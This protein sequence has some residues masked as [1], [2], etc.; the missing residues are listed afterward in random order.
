MINLK[1][2]EKEYSEI[3]KEINIFVDDI[4]KGKDIEGYYFN[5]LRQEVEKLTRQINLGLLSPN[6][7]EKIY[8]VFESI[9]ILKEQPNSKN[10]KLNEIINDLFDFLKYVIEYFMFEVENNFLVKEDY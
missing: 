8:E 4:N 3:I 2:Q 1:E 7:Y 10:K 5:Y 9:I 6:Y